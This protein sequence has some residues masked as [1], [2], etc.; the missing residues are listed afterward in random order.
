V[1]ISGITVD[2]DLRT[3]VTVSLSTGSERALA[4]YLGSISSVSIADVKPDLL[5]AVDH[6][7]VGSFYLQQ[8]LRPDLAS[9][10][11][12]CRAMR[13]TTSLDPGWDPSNEWNADILEVLKHVTVFLPNETEAMAITAT[14]SPEKAIDLLSEH[15]DIVL[16]KMGDKGCL[17]SNGEEKLH[18][19]AYKVEVVDVT[20]AGDA[21]NAG[22][23]Y[24]FLTG[25]D[26][27]GCTQFAN[28]CGA[29][30]VT[31]VGSLGITSGPEEVENFLASEP[32]LTG[33]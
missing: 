18:V 24:A 32:Q 19:P 13:L 20:S 8:T 17:A 12:E 15:A 6:V 29:L 27:R 23:L 9:L 16:V 14:N 28:A 7:H 5:R 3:G 26:L 30:A 25:R 10:F 2:P 11:E 21:C 33:G 31:R 4:T 1:G 22:F